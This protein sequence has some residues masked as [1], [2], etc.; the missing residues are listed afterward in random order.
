MSSQCMNYFYEYQDVLR[1][2][3]RGDL[4]LGNEQNESG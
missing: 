1:V 4:Y 2:S 3:I